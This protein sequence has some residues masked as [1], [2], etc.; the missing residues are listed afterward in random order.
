L[1]KINHITTKSLLI[2]GLMFLSAA[3]T[4]A[5]LK[6]RTEKNFTKMVRQSFVGPGVQISNVI[7]RGDSAAIG[8]FDGRNTN[9]GLDS[10]I[11]ITTGKA[12]DAIGP[13]NIDASTSQDGG[14]T[15][16]DLNSLLSGVTTKDATYLQFTF[17]PSSDNATF[18]IVFASEEYEKYTG[19]PFNDIFGFFLSGP[20]ITGK[21]NLALVP[22]TQDPISINTIN[23]TVNSNLF[24]NNIGGLTI[25]YNGFT[26]VIKIVA[27]NLIACEDYV[28]KMAIADVDDAIYDSGI[29]LASLNSESPND[30]YISRTTPD[31]TKTAIQEK[32]DS[33][34]FR[35]TRAGNLMQANQTVKFTIGGSA[36]RGIDYVDFPDSIIIPAG[37]MFADLIIM[38]VDDNTPEPTESVTISVENNS[39]C[40]IAIDSILI[41]DFDTLDITT[42]VD[43]RCEGDTIYKQVKFTGGSIRLSFEW[44]DSLG[45][46]KGVTPI[47]QASPDSLTM[48]IISI[49]DSCINFTVKD[50]IYI[51]P[52]TPVDLII[53]NDTVVCAPMDLNI[54]IQSSVPGLKYNWTATDPGQNAVGLFDD[55]AKQNPIYSVPSGVYTIKVT[56][57]VDSP[58]FCS[59]QKSFLIK[60]IPKGVFGPKTVYVCKGD[61]TTLRAYGGGTYKWSPASGIVGDTAQANVV[62]YKEG[63]YNVSV[64]DTIN[65]E[66]QYSV[67]V[68]FDTIPRADAGKDVVI[69]ER[70]SIQLLASGSQ[71][72]TY[73]WAPATGLTNSKIGNPIA[74]PLVTTTYVLKSKNNACFNYDTMTIFVITKPE[75]NFT[76]NF[77]SCA[78][79]ISFSNGTLGTDSFYWDFG[80]N[81]Y[82]LE[83]NPMHKYDTTGKLMVSLIANRGTDCT[84]TTEVELNL[85]DVDPNKRVV[86]NVFTPNGD[87]K[88]DV[89]KITGGNVSCA[90]TKMSI[91]NRWGKLLHEIKDAE[92]W[93][94]DGRI[95][96][97]IVPPGVYFYSIIGQGFEDVGMVNVIY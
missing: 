61:S 27:E 5:Q 37:R 76:Y 56:V 7:F 12:V 48:Y 39:V 6:V 96:G 38:P 86:P 30:S 68:K 29:F 45:A 60:V 47:L 83:R 84:D 70:S 92:V 15:D 32:C 85:I 41:Q 43:V 78:K 63:S 71:Y 1:K 2:I 44:T 75:T 31:K 65:C 69:C 42:F 97:E 62:V 73:E 90:I 16:G 66:K 53:P 54:I 19:F 77:D 20:G 28:L 24:V 51:P 95:G 8:I 22:G 10:G 50:T 33:A 79:V 80:D 46:I 21:K 11:L 36:V 81:E 35:F 89:F 52:L 88:N 59:G 87:N 13:D 34:S 3:S 94:W 74:S 58:N 26:K 91:Y 14:K 57:E 25:Q 17:T 49:Y 67:F 40:A 18:N 82:S 64:T 55:N 4:F 72:N 93:E 23:S 9:I